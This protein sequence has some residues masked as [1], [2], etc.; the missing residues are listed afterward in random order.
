MGEKATRDLLK[1]TAET[2]VILPLSK[3]PSQFRESFWLSLV[4]NFVLHDGFHQRRRHLEDARPWRTMT[5]I[6]I[7]V[8]RVVVLLPIESKE[9]YSGFSKSLNIAVGFEILAVS[10]ASFGSCYELLGISHT[11]A[12]YVVVLVV[13]GQD[14]E[15]LSFAFV[16]TT[17]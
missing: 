17:R 10:F 7:L 2:V 12:V 11:L 14:G 13:V 5:P 16:E 1:T 15:S 6:L 4:H 8:R 9:P 3:Q